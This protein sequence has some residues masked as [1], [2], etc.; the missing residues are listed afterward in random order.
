MRKIAFLFIL[1]F[2][3]QISYGQKVKNEHIPLPVKDAFQILY[4]N[5]D[6][7]KWGKEGQNYEANL[8]VNKKEISVIFDSNGKLIG[9]EEDIEISEL[10]TNAREYLS[11]NFPKSKIREIEKDTDARGIISYEV[12]VRGKE[13]IFDASGNFIKETKD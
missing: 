10:P 4:P 5:A 2:C 9:K 7:V 6:K 12:E 1:I 11:K 13:L 3:F 8:K